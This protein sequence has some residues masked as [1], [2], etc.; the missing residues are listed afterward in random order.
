[1][2]GEAPPAPVPHTLDKVSLT[3]V[4]EAAPGPASLAG[5]VRVLTAERGTAFSQALNHALFDTP[6]DYL[7]V[8]TGEL[9]REAA[10]WTPCSRNSARICIWA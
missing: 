3:V 6:A 10:A 4:A 1:V 7:V 2:G 5:G 9:W 8:S